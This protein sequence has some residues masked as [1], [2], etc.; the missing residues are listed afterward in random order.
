M[1]PH[2]NLGYVAHDRDC[3]HN[4]GMTVDVN[5]MVIQGRILPPPK[6]GAEGVSQ[7]QPVNGRWN[8]QSQKVFQP[9]EIRGCGIIIYDRRFGRAQEEIL[10]ST[11]YN[12]AQSLGIR[13]MPNDPPVLR[14]L[15]TGTEHLNVSFS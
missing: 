2:Q 6:I 4:L 8:M 9:A 13:S 10:K 3:F 1:H 15:G 12:T 5:P 11:L 7:I 14:R